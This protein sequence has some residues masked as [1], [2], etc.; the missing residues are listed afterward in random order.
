MPTT[1]HGTSLSV[2][3]VLTAARPLI[4][5]DW[6]V[7]PGHDDTGSLRSE[8]GYIVTLDGFAGRS[9][10]ASALLPDGRRI[11]H[12]VQAA[13]ISTE[14]FAIALASLVRGTFIPLHDSLSSVHR[15]L[16][17]L[18]DVLDQ[19]RYTVAWQ[20]GTAHVHWVLAGGGRARLEIRPAAA[21]AEST[22][23][24]ISVRFSDPAT[25][26]AAS[27]LLAI[28]T[29]NA[30]VR[31]FDRVYGPLAVRLKDAGP[32]LRPVVT[33]Q[34]PSGERFTA[35]LQVDNRVTVEIAAR[36]TGSEWVTGV[37]VTGPLSTVLDAV[38]AA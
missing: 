21:G 4:G 33:Y 23:A 13:T 34:H 27:V 20:R 35:V 28:G 8:R 29:D 7:Y 2:R 30:D 24:R 36:G 1:M 25:E 18:R 32:G 5:R 16:A 22:Q 31:R 17:A 9:V 37:E 14:G 19:R 6:A 11:G 26:A 3:D 38:R 10:F 15:A 12:A